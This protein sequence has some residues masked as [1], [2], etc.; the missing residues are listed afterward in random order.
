LF[1]TDLISGDLAK[2]NVQ[3]TQTL[4][5]G[6]RSAKMLTH[7]RVLAYKVTS[8]FQALY[9]EMLVITVDCHVKCAN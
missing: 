1:T 4:E 3:K 9:T 6:N 5:R 8:K 2:K 7:F